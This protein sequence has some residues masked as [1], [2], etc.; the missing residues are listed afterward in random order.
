MPW[1]S[2]QDYNEAI[3]SPQANLADPDL[4]GA[5]AAVNALGLPLPCSGNFA[6][7]Y[8]LTAPGGGRSWAVKCFTRQT[9]GLRERY[10]E[11]GLHLERV[12]LPF[13]VDF[14]FLDRGIRVRGDWYPVL[15]MQWVEGLLLNQFVREYLDKPPVLETLC[16]LWAKLAG[17]LRE[18][19]VAHG[20][21]QHGNVLLVPGASANSLALKLIDYDGMWVPALA[22]R[23]SGE[24]GHTAYQHP[25]RL[26]EGTYSAEADRFPH[27]VIYTALRALAVGGRPLWERYDSG[28]NLLFR[29]AD[30]A[31]PR[32]SA[33]LRELV[34]LGDG[35]LRQ[36]AQALAIASQKPLE[37]TPLLED[38][39]AAGAS[40]RVQATGPA[41]APTHNIQV[42]QPCDSA[43]DKAAARRR[44]RPAR[45]RRRP[46]AAL[47][48]AGVGACVLIAGLAVG[49]AWY[50]MPGEKEPGLPGEV[51]SGAGP[52][53]NRHGEHA[54]PADAAPVD[55]GARVPEPPAVDAAPPSPPPK[56][57][58]PA[59]PAPAPD[60]TLL[61]E[62]GERTPKQLPLAQP[63]P[64]P[65]AKGEPA[66]AP[67]D[68]HADMTKSAAPA[69]KED[70]AGPAEK[71]PP[72]KA[73]PDK[74]GMVRVLS[75][76]DG[77]IRGVVFL[78]DG[79]RALSG[80]S[81]KTVRLWDLETGRELRRFRGHTEE[82]TWVALAPDGTRFASASGDRSVRIWDIGGD[83][84][85]QVLPSHPG[86]LTC[87]AFSPDGRR[88]IAVGSFPEILIWD[89]K[90]GKIVRRISVPNGCWCAAFGP[91]RS[92][93]FA[94]T[95]GAPIWLFTGNGP[96]PRFFKGHTQD[97]HGFAFSRSGALIASSSF[98]GTVC[99]WNA[100]TGREI[101]SFRGHTGVVNCVAFSP[102][103][104]RIISAGSADRA[105]RLW[106]THSGRQLR[107]LE[108][109]AGNVPCVAI[110][111]DGRYALSGGDDCTLILWKLPER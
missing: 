11:I 107:L 18:A 36:L 22:R 103:G 92:G 7:V 43:G 89:W 10:R 41:A 88:L 34:G 59:A 19:G 49:A 6:D 78:P 77:C 74:E 25:Q 62:K 3:Q 42:A 97:V 90:G 85:L 84:E 95:P 29:Q 40:S 31:A 105:L 106:E 44:E 26:R 47:V 35:E 100:A 16:Q 20:D 75:G 1:P 64:P 55:S 76:H 93:S 82:V 32:E 58:A 96:T 81:D 83:H 4:R 21:L 109:H 13:M 38:I 87:V 8:R 15:K 70:R 111:P 52:G 57:P 54:G 67:G 39:S 104:S 48:A 28:D 80:A 94:V 5:E 61:P 60:P 46:A 86:P 72:P 68:T 108:G 101:R 63:E 102:D 50:C 17:R 110:S 51:A 99:L 73:R 30:F 56:Q 53:G 69:D 23:P 71:A 27:L 2:S 91:G 98:D 66:P 14:T 45:R 37:D 12:R 24:V 33:V 65:I 9:P 79:R